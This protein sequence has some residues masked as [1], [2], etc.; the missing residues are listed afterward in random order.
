M[1]SHL[2]GNHQDNTESCVFL[3]K[4]IHLMKSQYRGWGWKK[5]VVVVVGVESR[6]RAT[7]EQ[8]V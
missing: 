8:S 3:H 2:H 5:V 4:R 1:K 7:Q 6:G